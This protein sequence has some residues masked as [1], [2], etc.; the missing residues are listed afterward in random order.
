MGILFEVAV[1]VASTIFMTIGGAMFIFGVLSFEPE[2]TSATVFALVAVP[3]AALLFVR[4][5]RAIMRD[6]R[7]R[8]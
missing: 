5:G 1:W 6:L 4:T 2:I 3:I 8:E 7:N